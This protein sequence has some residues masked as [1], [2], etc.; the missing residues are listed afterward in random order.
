MPCL[1]SLGR[2]KITCPQRPITIND[3]Y[4]T[5]TAE[6]VNDLRTLAGL[7]QRNC[8]YQ[9]AQQNLDHARDIE[10]RHSKAAR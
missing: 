1:S 7:Q 9:E 6:A 8:L 2:Q 5:E 10:I 3:R 4:G